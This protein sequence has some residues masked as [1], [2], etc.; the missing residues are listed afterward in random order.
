MTTVF[1]SAAPPLTVNLVQVFSLD[2]EDV[3]I[4][5]NKV[6]GISILILFVVFFTSLEPFICC[7]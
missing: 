5:E 7:F 1:G 2:S 6:K 4:L 3:P